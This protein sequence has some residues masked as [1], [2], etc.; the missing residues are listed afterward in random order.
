MISELGYLSYID[1]INNEVILY[2]AK[3]QM[4]N[5]FINREYKIENPKACPYTILK[6]GCRELIEAVNNLAYMQ[7]EKL[8]LYK[9]DITELYGDMKAA[10]IEQIQYNAAHKIKLIEEEM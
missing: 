6:G 3:T 4:I 1:Y 10:A 5:D 2:K 9:E 7:T 8:G